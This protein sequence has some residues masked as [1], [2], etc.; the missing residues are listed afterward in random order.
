MLLTALHSVGQAIV[1]LIVGVYILGIAFNVAVGLV[2]LVRPSIIPRSQQTRVD[3]LVGTFG[4]KPDLP[5]RVRSVLLLLQAATWP[6]FA[7]ANR[8]L[9]TRRNN[10]HWASQLAL[11][12]PDRGWPSSAWQ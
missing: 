8:R 5:G 3:L 12:P 9:L 11:D 7:R 4:R 10:L 2:V 6:V 1:S